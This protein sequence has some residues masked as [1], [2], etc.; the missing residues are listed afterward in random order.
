MMSS[1]VRVPWHRLGNTTNE[2][3]PF[4]HRSAIGSGSWHGLRR[5][6]I[7]DRSYA[8]DVTITSLAF[9]R[10]TSS[11]SSLIT[12]EISPTIR[13]LGSRLASSRSGCIAASRGDGS[14]MNRP[15]RRPSAAI[16]LGAECQSASSFESAASTFAVT[17][18]YG[19]SSASDG[20]NV[21]WYNSV[22]CMVPPVSKWW[23]KAN[24][25]PRW[26][27]SWALYPLDPSRNTSGEE[28]GTGVAENC[29]HMPLSVRG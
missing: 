9:V 5:P 23:A 15:V 11:S 24:G 3:R 14:R 28:T 22:A 6:V 13:L 2:Q 8:T 12:T 26:P 21:W 25:S 7:R 1:V 10:A 4:R 27:A 16:R 17:I 19:A 18:M 20:W 29:R